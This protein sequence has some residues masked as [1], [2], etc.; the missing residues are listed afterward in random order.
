MAS[1]PSSPSFS[2]ELLE[3]EGEISPLWELLK[4][5]CYKQS[6]HTL[7]AIGLALFEKTVD[8]ESSFHKVIHFTFK[9]FLTIFICNVNVTHLLLPILS[10][11]ITE[12]Y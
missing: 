10:C 2:Q 1:E 8:T 6:D 4:W 7:P 9:Y 11:D 5:I 12:I 3:H